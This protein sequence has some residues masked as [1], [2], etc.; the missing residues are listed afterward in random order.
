MASTKPFEGFSYSS[1]LYVVTKSNFI[2]Q[3]HI[4]Y[5]YLWSNKKHKSNNMKEK[6]LKILNDVFDWGSILLFTAI[7]VYGIGMVLGIV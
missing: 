3:S 5:I 2:W 4:Y 7:V 6:L 1:T